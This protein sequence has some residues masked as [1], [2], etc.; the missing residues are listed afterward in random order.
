MSHEIVFRVRCD[1]LDEDGEQ[2]QTTA[3]SDDRLVPDVQSLRRL[4][5]ELEGWTHFGRRD[6]CPVHEA[7]PRVPKGAVK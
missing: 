5:C 1:Y 2:C 6:Y 4:L 3:S 7:G